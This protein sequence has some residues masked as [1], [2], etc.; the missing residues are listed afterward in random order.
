MICRV[1]TE[2]RVA[3]SAMTVPRLPATIALAIV[4]LVLAAGITYLANTLVSQP[5]GLSSEPATLG[6]SLAP[7]QP[8]A[9]SRP[10]VHK[11]H[12]VT[13]TVTTTVSS[14]APPAAAPPPIPAAP[15]TTAAASPLGDDHGGRR[16]GDD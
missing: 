11:S 2:G 15:P 12:P 13:K 1:F 5:I 14:A 9:R 7:A 3:S 16:D 8:T 4:G 6:R 10:A